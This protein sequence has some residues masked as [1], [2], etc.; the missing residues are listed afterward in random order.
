[1]PKKDYY[2]ILGVSR[3]ASD[4]DIRTAYKK[5]IKEWHPDRH[6]GDDK[7]VA[8]QKFKE[9]QEAYEVL[10]DPQKRA[11]YDKFGYVGDGTPYSYE[12]NG[13]GGFGFEDVF[14][15]FLNDDIFNI[16]FGGQHT[17]GRPTGTA[18]GQRS[19]RRGE[20]VHIN[21][22][23][24]ES[25]VFSGK[26][27]NIEYERYEECENC[28]GEGVEPGSKWITCS[29]CHGSGVVREERRTPFG[30]FVNQYTCDA[31]GGSGTIPGQTCHV[32][33][34]TGRIRKHAS[35]NINIPAGI[36]NGTTLRIPRRGNAGVNGGEYGDLY[37]HV[38]IRK[39]SN[40]EREGDDI[41]CNV[42]VDYITAILGGE[43][44]VTL[45]NNEEVEIEI[46]AGVQPNET[47]IVKG[48]GYPNVRNG[49]RGNFIAR[50][51]VDIPRK[52]SPKEK[53]L[54]KE[55]ARMKGAKV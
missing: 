24:D 34:S 46:P 12:T 28:H 27:L 9:I 26:A 4:E 3:S 18:R 5:L 15:D 36:E 52:V 29:K 45:P 43:V 25:D 21:V 2:E 7:K 47:V 23:I 11:M 30:V 38:N 37:I 1:M 48:K 33:R 54:L 10:S 40:Y 13:N 16:F 14:R 8:E 53:E 20:D 32:C 19:S 51:I 31:C 50:I 49:R 42:H 55:I 6:T 35:T 17:Q 44:T 39:V 41:I 22:S